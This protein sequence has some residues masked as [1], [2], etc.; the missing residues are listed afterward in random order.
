MA[1]IYQ[2]P[3]IEVEVDGETYKLTAYPAMVALEY[4][5]KLETGPSP[6]LIQDMVLKGVTKDSIAIDKQR[7]DQM[8]SGRIS[9]LMKVFAKVMEFNFTDPNAESDSESL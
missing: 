1:D 5:F 9:H 8:F 7:F 4:Q 3:S 6:A 2:R